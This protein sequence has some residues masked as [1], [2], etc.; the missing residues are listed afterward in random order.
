MF[1]TFLKYLLSMSIAA[2]LGFTG[3]HYVV[4]GTT[5]W[6]RDT[7]VTLSI[8]IRGTQN[9]P[10]ANASI[11][12]YAPNK[13]YLGK[14]DAQ[15][16]FTGKTRAKRGSVAI[17]EATGPT[18]KLRKDIP[19]PR[20]ATY[21]AFINLN[22]KEASM[23]HMTL[24]SKSIEDMSKGLGQKSTPTQT[25]T[26]ANTPTNVAQ[27]SKENRKETT[28]NN[29]QPTTVSVALSDD[30]TRPEHNA[31]ATL[32]ALRS[33]VREKES[34][35]LTKGISSVRL[36][37]LAAEETYFEVLG[38]DQQGS[39]VSSA[40]IKCAL[41]GTPVIENSV[42]ALLRDKELKTTKVKLRVFTANPE[43]ARAYVNGAALIRTVEGQYAQFSLIEINSKNERIA[44]AATADGRPLIRKIALQSAL[45]EI[46]EWYMPEPPLSRR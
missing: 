43:T 42:A 45:S 32:E 34:T 31:E 9:Q 25:N 35:L 26:A 38:L 19:I 6:S 40:L 7:Y 8:S 1:K 37:P 16:N 13:L 24:I 41:L 15:G 36:R 21:Q 30:R 18:Y 20:K 10:V 44:I 33:V 39:V 3:V 27:N 4:Y 11:Y 12:L 22:P 14:S 28:T 2:F 29:I 17:I 5:P 23:G 46:I